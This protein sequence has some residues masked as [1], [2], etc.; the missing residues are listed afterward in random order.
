MNRSI[1]FSN[2]IKNF[3]SKHNNNCINSIRPFIDNYSK[4]EYL[5]FLENYNSNYKYK[6]S[7]RDTYIKYGYK[8]YK[9]FS[10][11]KYQVN[12]IEWDPGSHSPIFSDNTVIKLINGGLM[13]HKYNN[14]FTFNKKNVLVP[15]HSF[16]LN[17]THSYFLKNFYS[18]VNISQGK[19]YS[20]HCHKLN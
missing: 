1:M 3:S 4:T 15:V 19:S 8:I 10:N 11:K 16:T 13:E 7:S 2:I 17:K 12:M 14:D 5:D 6:L 18:I 20:I 9:L